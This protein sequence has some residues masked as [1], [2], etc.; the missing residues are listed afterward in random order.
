ML[1]DLSDETDGD[2]DD[3]PAI[4]NEDLKK[5]RQDLIQKKK[6]GFKGY[7]NKDLLHLVQ[8]Q[9]I[10]HDHRH[11]CQ[12]LCDFI[13]NKHPVFS[14]FAKKSILD[15]L[16]ARVARLFLMI[17][18]SFGLNAFFFWD[19]YIEANAI[20]IIDGYEVSKYKF[21]LFFSFLY[22]VYKI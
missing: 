1:D 20:L 10:K 8:Q 9:A 2:D 22:Y 15:P 16:F 3:I 13:N 21:F 6:K 14:V 7:T 5:E 17:S 19:Q 11:F 12:Y 18:L 4:D